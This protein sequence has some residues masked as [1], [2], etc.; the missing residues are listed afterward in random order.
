M[1]EP[2]THFTWCE[3]TRSEAAARF[4]LSN[5]PDADARVRITTGKAATLLGSP[6]PYLTRFEWVELIV[7]HILLW[8]NAYCVVQWDD[9]MRPW[10]LPLVAGLLKP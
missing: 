1:I 9:K 7:G 3:L 2:S 4:H 8:G 5:E 10:L 6:H